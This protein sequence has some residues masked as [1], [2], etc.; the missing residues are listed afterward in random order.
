MDGSVQENRVLDGFFHF[1][2]DAEREQGPRLETKWHRCD[3]ESLL[4]N[5]FAGGKTLPCF[6]LS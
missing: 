2:L 4:E 1:A 5:Q 3:V 6:T